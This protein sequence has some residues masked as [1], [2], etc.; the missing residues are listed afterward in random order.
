MCKNCGLELNRAVLLTRTIQSG[1]EQFCDVCILEFERISRY[2]VTKQRVELP[3][4]LRKL[5]KEKGLSCQ[6]A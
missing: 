2:Y 5:R 3:K 1:E 4:L 6:S